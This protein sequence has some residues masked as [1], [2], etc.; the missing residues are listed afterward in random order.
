MLS[1]TCGDTQA[2]AVLPRYRGETEV[3]RGS[4]PTSLMLDCCVERTVLGLSQDRL[5]CW[6]LASAHISLSSA[7]F[8]D[9]SW[10]L[11]EASGRQC[12]LVGCSRGTH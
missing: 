3:Y 8:G 11:H 6:P 10:R 12:L 4:V 9:Q 1:H 7:V 2:T 5:W